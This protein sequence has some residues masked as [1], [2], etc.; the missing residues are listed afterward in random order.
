MHEYVFNFK[1]STGQTILYMYIISN[2]VGSLDKYIP[3]PRR[4]MFV[5]ALYRVATIRANSWT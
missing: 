5:H 1:Y 3:L 4:C 2:N